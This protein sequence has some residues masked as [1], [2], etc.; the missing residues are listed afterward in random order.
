MTLTEV[1]LLAV[2][3]AAAPIK[4]AEHHTHQ[5]KRQQHFAQHSH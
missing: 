5:Q 1:A 2:E 3:A 4:Q